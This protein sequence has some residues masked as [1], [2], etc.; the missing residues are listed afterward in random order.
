MF[1]LFTFIYTDFSSGHIGGPDIPRITSFVLYNMYLFVYVTACMTFVI[2]L[3]YLIMVVV[4]IPNVIDHYI[5]L[6]FV[7]HLT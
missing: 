1:F 4:N 2:V 5:I 6:L 7:A 3:R